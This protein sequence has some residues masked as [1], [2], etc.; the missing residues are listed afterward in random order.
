MCHILKVSQEEMELLTEETD[1]TKGA[2]KLLSWGPCLVLVSLGAQGAFFYTEKAK[3][4]VPAY[5]VKAVDITG[6]GDAF[7]GSMLFQLAGMSPE[8]I[9][10]LSEAQLEEMVS[11]ANGAGS[12][13]TTKKGAIPAMP[14]QEE[15]QR[16]RKETPL[17]VK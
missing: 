2:Q 11:F 12:L 4:Q 16:C 1:L 6:A 9:Q 7:V 10:N 13:T 3:G 15:I 5:Q 8:E 14:T 17:F